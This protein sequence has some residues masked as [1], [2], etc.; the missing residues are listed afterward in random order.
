MSKNEKRILLIREGTSFLLKAIESRL[1]EKDYELIRINPVTEELEEHLEDA[2][3]FMVYLGE[4]A[5][6][7][8]AFFKALKN[9]AVEKGKELCLVG[10]ISEISLA[11]NFIPAN[12]IWKS[13]E[14]PVDLEVLTED[15][16]KL[17]KKF[18]KETETKTLLLVDDDVSFLKIMTEWLGETYRLVTVTSGMQAIT[19]LANNTPD[20]ILLDYEM[21]VTPGPQVLE[22][23]RSEEKSKD[24]PVMFLTSKN[25][26]ESVEKVL[27]LNPVR[28]ILKTMGRG[29]MLAIL[30]EYFGS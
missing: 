20:L 25:D 8:E 6:K 9:A 1:E 24:I 22:M 23:I 19:Y 4:F 27:S 26:R 2:E 14:R 7:A 29:E 18:D 12:A 21:P 15:L 28:Y 30:S 11:K 3:I 16:G 13:Y 17:L 10:T 5:E